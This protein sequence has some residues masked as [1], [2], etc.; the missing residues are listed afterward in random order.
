MSWIYTKLP[1]KNSCRVWWCK[2]K[3]CKSPT[4]KQIRL[5]EASFK[6]GGGDS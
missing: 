2:A 5:D 4:T 1:F 6:L 3:H